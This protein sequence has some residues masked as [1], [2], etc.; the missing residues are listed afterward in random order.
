MS[1]YETDTLETGAEFNESV[2]GKKFEYTTSSGT[3]KHYVIISYNASTGKHSV[4]LDGCEK[5]KVKNITMADVTNYR[6]LDDGGM[7]DKIED[8]PLSKIDQQPR[9]RAVTTRISPRRTTREKR[10]RVIASPAPP[11][12]IK[13][14]QKAKATASPKQSL[15]N[16][17]AIARTAKKRSHAKTASKDTM[18]KNLKV[19]DR[20]VFEFTKGLHFGHIEK[21][22]TKGDDSSNWL[23]EV[24]FDDGDRYE[25]DSKDMTESTNLYQAIK[26][27]ELADPQLRTKLLKVKND[28]LSQK[29][30]I[31]K[32]IPSDVKK[33]YFQCGFAQWGSKDNYYLPVLFLGPYDVSPGDV[34]DTWL[35]KFYQMVRKIFTY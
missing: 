16:K 7:E 26:K 25:F 24:Q 12:K 8:T 17:S 9:T 13:K 21:C 4:E 34:R 30:D 15:V 20:T 33:I 6:W 18:L 35:K 14:R 3:I 27:K 22:D 32:Q 10:A 5:S 19:D 28:F 23:W 1:L 2:I 29:K 11:T 31:M